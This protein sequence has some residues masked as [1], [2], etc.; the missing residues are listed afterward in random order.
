MN[1]KEFFEKFYVPVDVEDTQAS[2]FD[3]I[4]VLDDIYCRFTKEEAL[5]LVLTYYDNADEIYSDVLSN[6]QEGKDFLVHLSETK[7]G[8]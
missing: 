8:K 6:T 2:R 1:L 4:N 5:E 7:L 3:Y